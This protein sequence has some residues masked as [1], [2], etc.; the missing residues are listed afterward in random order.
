[1]VS[2]VCRDG[3]CVECSI[4]IAR[5]YLLTHFGDDNDCESAK[6]HVTKD[7]FPESVKH[8]VKMLESASVDGECFAFTELIEMFHSSFFLDLPLTDSLAIAIFERYVK[9]RRADE[10][11]SNF[12][13][14]LEGFISS[15]RVEE[16]HQSTPSQPFFR[17]LNEQQWEIL[18]HCWYIGE[19]KEVSLKLVF[20][21]T[22]S[23][24][25]L[26]AKVGNFVLLLGR[27]TSALVSRA[28][29]ETTARAC[30]RGRL[31]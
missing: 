14:H 8:L 9:D 25:G 12:G 18:L 13:P 20:L 22:W 11:I 10:I 31:M 19:M 28:K 30:T 1:M 21:F 16:R 4:D 23:Y 17:V 5:K 6:L 24:I 27:R 26:L 15:D 7:L 29:P 2:L 3:I